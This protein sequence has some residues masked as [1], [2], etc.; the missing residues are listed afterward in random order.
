MSNDVPSD[1]K[2]TKT[3]EWVR[4]ES[5][6]SVTVVGVGPDR[7]EQA[8]R[9]ALAMGADTA[10]LVNDPAA[11]DSD[12]LGIAKILAGVLKEMSYDLVIAGVRAASELPLAVGFGIGTPA[13]AQRVAAAADGVNRGALDEH[14]LGRRRRRAFPPLPLGDCRPPGLPLRCE[15]H[16]MHLFCGR[17]AVGGRGT[18]TVQGEL[19]SPV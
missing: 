15:D 16:R 11:E 2:Y 1:L 9:T 3:H 13:Q 19:G 12:A 5:D 14:R 18:G 8:L 10:I 4:V 6:G 17:S 7:S